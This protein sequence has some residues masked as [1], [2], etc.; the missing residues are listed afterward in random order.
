ML[1][2]MSPAKEGEKG[3]GGEERPPFFVLLGSL[4][5]LL[6]NF[7]EMRR[8]EASDASTALYPTVWRLPTYKTGI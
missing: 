1:E 6:F 4:P 3:G 7:E 2:T 5:I 8:K